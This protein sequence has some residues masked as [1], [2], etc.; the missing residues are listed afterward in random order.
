MNYRRRTLLI[1]LALGPPLAGCQ[2][3]EGGADLGANPN[4]DII[5]YDPGPEFHDAREDERRP[6]GKSAP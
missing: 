3:E 2:I 4:G 6:T 5:Y 1:M